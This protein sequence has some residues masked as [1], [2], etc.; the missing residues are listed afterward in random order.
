V[1]KRNNVPF[2]FNS[3]LCLKHRIIP[4]AF[5]ECM[6]TTNPGAPLQLQRP[7]RSYRSASNSSACLSRGQLQVKGKG[8]ISMGRVHHWGSFWR[9]REAHGVG[10][11][12]HKGRVH[13]R[14]TMEKGRLHCRGNTERGRI[15]CRGA[16]ERGRVHC[17]GT[18]GLGSVSWNQIR[19]GPLDQVLRAGLYLLHRNNQT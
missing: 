15:H 14:G 7:V 4:L 9:K 8:E 11:L 5:T 10:L 3:P 18:M 6:L 19:T 2:H 17:R 12:R 16:T 13:C 1:Q